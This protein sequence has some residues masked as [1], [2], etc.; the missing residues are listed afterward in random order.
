MSVCSL[1][2]ALLYQVHPKLT[3]TSRLTFICS[4]NRNSPSFKSFEEKVESTVSNIK[5]LRSSSF[6]YPITA[7]HPP[8]EHQQGGQHGRPGCITFNVSPRRSLWQT[9]W[10][11][12]MAMYTHLLNDVKQQPTENNN[13]RQR[14][15]G[16]KGNRGGERDREVW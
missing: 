15:T 16:R 13:T 2:R 8:S 7:V 4:T 10:L 6:L 3:I 11:S 12:L 1:I 5:V 14:E 9:T